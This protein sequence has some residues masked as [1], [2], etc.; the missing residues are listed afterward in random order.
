MQIPDEKQGRKKPQLPRQSPDRALCLARC[1]QQAALS[2]P[3]ARR[4]PM[5]ISLVATRWLELGQVESST[6]QV[7]ALGSHPDHAG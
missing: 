7:R 4:E 6:R 1:S 3:L 5:A 2:S